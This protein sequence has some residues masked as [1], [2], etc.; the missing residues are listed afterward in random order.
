MASG[1]EI[2][3]RVAR[4]RPALIQINSLD[5]LPWAVLARRLLGVPIVYDSN[6]DYEF[7]MLDKEWLPHRLRRPLGRLV[8]TLEP[9]LAERLDATL[10]A[11]T[12][13]AAR[14]SGSRSPVLAIHNFPWR[15]FGDGP[16]AASEP[17]YD[18][19][20]HGTLPKSYLDEFIPIASELRARGMDVRWCFAANDFRPAERA[21]LEARLQT[22]GLRDAFALR[23]NVPFPEIPDVLA[24]TRLGLIPLPPGPV[25]QRS[26]P[27]KLFEFLAFGRPAV[28]SDLP[29]VRRLVGDADCCLLVRPGDTLGFSDA[30]ERLLRD[31]ALA[32][33]MGE[34]GR[35]LVRERLHAERELQPYVDLCRRLLGD[36][37]GR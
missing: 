20:Y 37:D 27:M 2:M 1:P 13:T 25:V 22:A 18:V 30:V 32:A 23:Y 6:D 35:N 26:L 19:T 7:K 33:E 28:V 3:W 4:S 31:P 10:V 12:E 24:Q 34:R 29:A 16:Q 21:E 5:L 14:F 9:W 17:R 8:A 15:E 36:D 11:T